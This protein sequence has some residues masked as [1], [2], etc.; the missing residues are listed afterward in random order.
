[1]RYLIHLF[2][3]LIYLFLGAPWGA[4]ANASAPPILQVSNGLYRGPRPDFETLENLKSL[5]VTIDVDLENDQEVIAAERNMAQA[6]GIQFVSMPMSPLFPP[7]QDEVNEILF[8]LSEDTFSTSVF[9]H[10]QHGQD[11]T[12]LIIGLYRVFYENW[13]P[14]DAYREMLSLGFHQELFFLNHYFEA[15]TGFED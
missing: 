15:V 5:G 8:K 4:Q 2:L 3:T 13:T 7:Q 6:L 14:A 12:G 11:R 10:C 1:M 9:V